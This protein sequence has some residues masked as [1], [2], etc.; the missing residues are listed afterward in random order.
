[1]LIMESGDNLARHTPNTSIFIVEFE[2]LDEI[3]LMLVAKSALRREAICI[4]K[5]A[6]YS[7]PPGN[8]SVVKAV[9]IQLVMN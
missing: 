1:M 4:A 5:G 6:E 3:P 9:D 8:V 7:I 2:H